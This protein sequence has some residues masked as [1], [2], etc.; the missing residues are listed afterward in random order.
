MPR[1]LVVCLWIC[2][3]VAFAAGAARAADANAW[4][5]LSDPAQDPVPQWIWGPTEARPGEVLNFRVAFDPQLPAVPMAENPSTATLWVAGDDDATVHLNGKPVVRQSKDAGQ[6]SVVAD[7]RGALVPG[8]N[9][10]TVTCRN[11]AGPAAVAVKLV[12][13]GTYREPFTLVT[14]STWTCSADAPRGWRAKA[15]NGAGF[16]KARVIGPY[17]IEPWGKLE[18]SLPVTG[19]TPVDEL[20]LLPGFKAELLYS[21]PKSTQGSWV[22]MASDSKGRLYVSDQGGPLFRV[23]PGTDAAST[24][25]ERVDLD[26]GN[27]QGLLWAN[28]SLYV[29]VNGKVQSRAGGLYRLRDTDNDDRLDKIDLLL[30]LKDRSGNGPAGGEH[31]PHAVVMGPD[32]KV[33][34]VAGNFTGLPSP[35][36][37]ASPAAHW[38]EDLLLPREPDGRGH[39]PNIMAPGGWVCRMNADGTE[40]EAVATGLRNAYDIAFSPDGE[41]FTFDSDMEWDVGAPWYRPTRICHVVSG[42]EF[43]WR[44]GSGKWP[45]YYPDSV[46]A[47]VD[48]GPGSPTGVTFGTGAKFPAKYQHCLFANDWAYGK[49]FAVHLQPNGSSYTATFEPFVTAKAFDVTDL[50]IHSDGAMYVL[51]GGRNTQSGLYRIT[52][53][54]AE[55]TAPVPYPIDPAAAK[56]RAVRREL[57]SFH[58]RAGGAGAVDAAWPHLASPDRFIRYAARVALESQPPALWQDRALGATDPVVATQAALALCRV[59][60]QSLQPQVLA[61]LDRVE[62]GSLPREQ[63]LEL[64]RTYA[65]CFIRMGRPDAATLGRC[66]ARWDALFPTR[67]AAVDHELGQLLVYVNSPNV[68]T[69][70]MALL[71]DARTQE[72]QLF[73]A[74]TLRTVEAG[75]NPE[76]RTAYFRWLNMAEEKYTG[77]ASFKL[78]LQHIRDN[79]TKT[80]TADERPALADLLKGPAAAPARPSAVAVAGPRAFVRRWQV[81]DFAARMSEVDRGRSYASG[82]AAFE[83][84]SCAKCHRFGPDNGTGAVGPDITGVGSRFS[85]HDILESILLPSKA[86]SDQYRDTSVVTKNGIAAVGQIQSEDDEKIVLRPS[87]LLPQTETILKK[88]V[89]RRGP[90]KLSAMPEGLLDVLTEDEVLD[91]LAYLRSGGK[92]D[93]G[94]FKK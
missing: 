80:L 47:A 9:V 35:L 68:V 94:A 4:K 3:V 66:A 61:A 30:P 34:L 53:T 42:A 17:G 32:G 52:Y 1:L 8:R 55:S 13:R 60:D 45:T 38:A 73:W 70:S 62:L 11:G 27:A 31:G 24:R 21:V 77:G 85:A 15:F 23:T 28:D 67:D 37:S 46:P 69:K 78:F 90:A 82:K 93:D 51:I 91:L 71:A 20:A 19:A 63:R 26:I 49:I 29:V 25:V 6:A 65:V 12:V 40:V 81:A 39:D 87:P 57:E 48:V 74:L 7:V 59:G 54:G 92:S 43:G 44:N 76:L 2:T 72:E 5:D 10:L 36:S 64:L 33:Y 50:V 14:D 41:L 84:V 86:I 89:V 22:S 88:N 16:D 18:V 79:A 58:G 75:W 56:A 83:A